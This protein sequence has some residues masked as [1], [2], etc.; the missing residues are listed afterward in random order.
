MIKP[1]FFQRVK[2]TISEFIK[3]F[4]MAQVSSSAN[5]LA[6]YSL[7][8]IFPALIVVGN[9]LPILGV[10]ATTLL[11]YLETIIPKSIFAFIKPIVQDSLS[12]GSGGL[13]TAGALI[14][15][16]STSQAVAA[17]QRGVNQAYGVAKD[18]DPITNRVLSFV[19]MVLV[20]VI[21]GAVILFYGV[22]ELLLVRFRTTF[23]I[24]TSVIDTVSQLRWPVSFFGVF[25]ALS[26]LYYFVP[27]AKVM[28]RYVFWGAL[29]TTMLWMLLSQVFSL[30]TVVFSQAVATYKTMGAFVVFMIWLDMSGMVM[31][32]GAVINATLQ[33]LRQG[34]IH[35]KKQFWKRRKEKKEQM[36]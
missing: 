35:E 25:I 14:T 27:N 34:E 28:Y 33:S 29:I 4:F 23:H 21:M 11:N 1:T 22:G 8:S 20:I 6:Y 15:L 19:W 24:Q 10:Q 9:L 5:V 32:I 7:L 31:M 13:L 17:F 3:H 12:N 30:Y 2:V 26:L 16:W 18:Q 36:E